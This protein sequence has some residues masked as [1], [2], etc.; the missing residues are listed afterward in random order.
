MNYRKLT[1]TVLLGA[2]VLAFAPGGASAQVCVDDPARDE[3]AAAY[4][5]WL[6]ALASETSELDPA[7]WRTRQ[8][9]VAAAHAALEAAIAVASSHTDPMSLAH[10]RTQGERVAAT[11]DASC[12][13]RAG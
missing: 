7:Q 10:G 9:D 3:L 12:R 4:D 8:A 6:R 2:G 5:T 11:L 1:A 13:S